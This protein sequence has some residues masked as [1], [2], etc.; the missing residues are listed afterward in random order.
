[1]KDRRSKND[2]DD[3]L[4]SYLPSGEAFGPKMLNAYFPMSLGKNSLTLSFVYHFFL[5]GSQKSQPKDK[6]GKRGRP[7]SFWSCQFLI[8][9]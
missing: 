9:I 2:I 6:K 1:M 4:G 3:P 7:L 5:F 8:F